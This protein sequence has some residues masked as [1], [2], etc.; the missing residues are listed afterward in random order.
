MSRLLA[1]LV[2]LTLLGPARAAAQCAGPSGPGPNGFEV[3]AY[4]ARGDGTTDD[5]DAI[6]CAIEAAEAQTIAAGPRGAQ[7][8]FA[9]GSYLVSRTLAVRGHYVSLAGQGGPFTTTVRRAA[10]FDSG[11]T[12]RVANDAQPGALIFGTN[13]SNLRLLASA[14]TRS[15]A[16]LH[17]VNCSRAA[18]TNLALDEQFGGL[19]LEGGFSLAFT[20]VDVFS[21]TYF[22]DVKP[23]S[24][25]VRI[26]PGSHAATNGNATDINF[27]GGNWRSSSGRARVEHGLR[28]HSADAIYFTNVHVLG[29][30][31]ADL[32]VEPASATAQVSGLRF[33]NCWFDPPGPKASAGVLIQGQ[34]TAPFGLIAFDECV[35]WGGGGVESASPVAARGIL[36]DSASLAGLSLTDSTIHGYG[37]HGL[38]LAAGSNLLVS[39]NQISNNNTNGPFGAGILVEPG[40]SDFQIVGNLVGP[41]LVTFTSRHSAGIVVKAGASDR[42]GIVGNTVLNTDA[43]ILDGGDGPDKRVS[44]NLTP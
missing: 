11:D 23:H 9:A 5:T 7:V 21:D 12:I 28:V 17:L 26:D 40:V 35:L 38:H 2:G 31:S 27:V 43:P 18:F 19:H 33:R 1:L 6:Q 29:G 14:E 30:A 24:Y 39:G 32:L 4:G 41:N 34:T 22:E 3:T 15:G 37:T 25:L 16:H 44:A 8:Y 13:I 10:G 36:V 20:N 42:Y